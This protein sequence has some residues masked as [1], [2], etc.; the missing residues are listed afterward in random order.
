M[1]LDPMLVLKI[2][3]FHDELYDVL[4]VKFVRGG[5]PTRLSSDLRKESLKVAYHGLPFGVVVATQCS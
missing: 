4:R 5:E 2:N 1:G 3:D